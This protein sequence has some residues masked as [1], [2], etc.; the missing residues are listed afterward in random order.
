MN[1]F[2]RSAVL[3]AG[4]L[5]GSGAALAHS[6][7]HE[8]RTP[9]QCSVMPSNPRGGGLRAGCMRCIEKVTRRGMRFHFHPDYPPGK[10]CRRDNG[11]P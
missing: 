9:E 4:L 6:N 3:A 8:A 2:L 10:R 5:G 11:R 7:G 1:V